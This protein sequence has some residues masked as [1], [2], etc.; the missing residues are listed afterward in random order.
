MAVAAPLALGIMTAGTVVGVGMQEKARREQKRASRIER[1]RARLSTRRQAIESVR[2]AQI[3]RAQVAAAGEV[4]GVG[5]ASGLLGGLGSIQSQ[6]GSNIGFLNTQLQMRQ[7]AENRLQS[8]ANYQF[9]GSA[10][11]SLASTF[12][13][14]SLANQ[15]S[16]QTTGGKG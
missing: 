5:Q 1:K 10:I 12:G 3:Q 6:A 11:S 13:Q 9:A 2:A 4:S 14:Y 15:P 16:P 7:Q 8:A